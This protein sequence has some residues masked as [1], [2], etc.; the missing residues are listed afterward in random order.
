MLTLNWA[1]RI[2]WLLLLVAAALP[3]GLSADGLANKGAWVPLQYVVNATGPPI[4]TH[5]Q[6]LVHSSVPLRLL[7]LPLFTSQKPH[8]LQARL[9]DAPDNRYDFA[10]DES[11]PG[12]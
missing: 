5:G 8:F 2:T 3:G 7:K 4:W 1:R 9:G 11:I 12:R 10:L 6:S